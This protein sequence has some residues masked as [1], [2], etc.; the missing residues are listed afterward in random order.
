[1]TWVTHKSLRQELQGKSS[2]QRGMKA[3][4]VSSLSSTVNPLWFADYAS[5]YD[6]KDLLAGSVL[7]LCA[8]RG[9]KRETPEIVFL[10]PVPLTSSPGLTKEP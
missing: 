6:V 4:L 2:F 10:A 5:E 1:M 3:W 7:P 8:E 9:A